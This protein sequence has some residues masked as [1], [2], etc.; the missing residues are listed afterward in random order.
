MRILYQF[1]IKAT[2]V[3]QVRENQSRW[4]K[5]SV[6]ALLFVASIFI[7]SNSSA[8]IVSDTV[9]YKDGLLNLRGT[10]AYDD[11]VK[12]P[13]PGILL[14]PEWWGHN[15]YIKR[16]AY[17]LAA[18]DYVV[19]IA[20]MYGDAKVTNDPK[21]AQEWS[22]E[23]YSNRVLMRERA[24][25]ALLVLK[26][27]KYLNKNNIAA[28]G[29]CMGGTVALEMARSGE[30]LKGVAAFHA[31]LQFP[32]PVAKDS[33]IAKILVMNGG[34]DPLVPVAERNAFVEEMQ[35]A[36][37]DLQFIQ[38]GG[39]MHAFT[40]PDATRLNIPGIAYNAKAERRSFKTLYSFLDEIF[41]H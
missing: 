4:Y 24:L 31:G 6:L 7:S 23:L 34:A 20:D 1:I 22:A 10:I 33:V 3:A 2:P 25:A 21:Q 36:D 30:D 18:R 17:E 11:A 9:E 39:A 27:Q 37:S 14:F 40:N 32:D 29:F 5:N 16:R 19:F 8:A 15:A 35:A 26:Q 41:G 13:R 12:T 28:I 38:Y